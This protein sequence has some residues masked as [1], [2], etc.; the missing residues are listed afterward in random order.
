MKA[1]IGRRLVG[2]LLR[3]AAALSAGALLAFLV[4]YDVGKGVA[5]DLWAL[6]DSNWGDRASVDQ[7][8][9]AGLARGT[10]SRIRVLCD[11]AERAAKCRAVCRFDEEDP[12]RWLELLRTHGRGLLGERARA[13]LLSGDT[14]RIVRSARRRDFSGVGLFPRD[15]D[16]YYLLNDFVM[17]MSRFKPSDPPPGKILL[18]G[19]V[20]GQESAVPQLIAIAESDPG[21][22]LSGAAFHSYLATASTKREI[23]LLGAVSLAVVL[24]LGWRLFG[25]LRFVEPMALILAAGFVAGAQAVFFLPTPPHAVTFLFGT[26]LIGLG[27]DYCYHG[28]SRIDAVAGPAARRDFVRSLTQALLTT[29]FAFAPLLFS[30]LAV[31][32]QMALFTITGLVVIYLLVL[33]QVCS[34]RSR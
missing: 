19:D 12:S 10:A 29:A 31:L 34:A 1:R 3:G 27:V 20:T 17:E 4:T 8:L 28:L 18:S 11:D 2:E 22:N 23:N 14:N 15:D 32:N 33:R 21:V 16:P 7:Q 26:S 25:N 5:T 9:V 24:L 30:K 13:E 6:A